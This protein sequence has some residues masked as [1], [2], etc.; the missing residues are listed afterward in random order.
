MPHCTILHCT[1]L[2]CTALHPYAPYMPPPN[3]DRH[4]ECP[5]CVRRIWHPDW[6]ADHRILEKVGFADCPECPLLNTFCYLLST[7]SLPSLHPSSTLPPP[8]CPPLAY[9]FNRSPSLPCLPPPSPYQPILCLVSSPRTLP[10]PTIATGM[11]EGRRAQERDVRRV[12]LPLHGLG[13][14]H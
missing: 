8:S 6:P 7:F 1:T 2:H 13:I 4:R 11:D 14:H 9:P 12:R 10:T 3:T 5:V